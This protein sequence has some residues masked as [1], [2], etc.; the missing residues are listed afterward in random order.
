MQIKSI[1]CFT[2]RRDPVLFAWVIIIATILFWAYMVL[3]RSANISSYF[4]SDFH[5]S[6]MDYFHMLANLHFDDPY[7]EQA[8]YPALCFVFFGVMYR[9]LPVSNSE[10][11]GDGFYLR[12]EMVAQL[13]YILFLM[14]GIMIIWS[15]AQVIMRGTAAQK[16]LFAAALLL[17]GP[18]LFLL[19]RGNV[20]LMALAFLMTFLALYDSEHISCRI[21]AYVA[22]AAA[23][24]LKIYP[25]VFGGLVIWKK[26]YKESVL[27]VLLGI[28]FFL[29]PFFCFNGMDSLRVMLEGIVKASDKVVGAGFGQ[30]YSFSNLVLIVSALFGG[31]SLTTPG[32]VDIFPAFFCVIFFFIADSEWKK[33]YA[34]ALFCIWF[35]QFAYTY[36]LTLMFLPVLSFYFRNGENSPFNGLYS[37]CFWIMM[38]PMCTPIVDRINDVA[39]NKFP[40]SLNTLLVYASLV[41]VL[42][43]IA[44]EWLQKGDFKRFYPAT[45]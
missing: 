38:I 44:I 12:T 6:S 28:A 1:L 32:W 36:T 43:C 35:P 16:N 7:Y 10:E 40:V 24:A 15:M 25:A 23:A 8:N 13:G 33:L 21:I 26:R 3:T 19:E 29:L 20:L 30:N 18:M 41:G 37:F 31:S 14:V 11:Y 9:M 2:K 34:L 17:S 22:L 27:L 45:K 39:G 42:L 4:L 5:D